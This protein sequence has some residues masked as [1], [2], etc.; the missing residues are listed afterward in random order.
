MSYEE[1]NG[2]IEKEFAGQTDYDGVA[3]GLSKAFVNVL[4][5]QQAKEH[6][7]LKINAVTPGYILTDLTAG[8]GATNP[9]EKGTIAPM[10]VS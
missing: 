6:P 8:M 5:Q 7:N 4:T 1:L 10:K 9:P 3:Y 2:V